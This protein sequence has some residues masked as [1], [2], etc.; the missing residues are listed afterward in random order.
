[1]SFTQSSNVDSKPVGV[2]PF[3]PGMS[4]F[5]AGTKRI[6]RLVRPISH[7]D[8][9]GVPVRWALSD[10]SDL[11]ESQLSHIDTFKPGDRVFTLN[12]QGEATYRILTVRSWLPGEHPCW[13]WGYEG[14]SFGVKEDKL[15]P[16]TALEVADWVSGVDS[17][18]FAFD[19]GVITQRLDDGKFTVIHDG[20]RLTLTAANLR[21]DRRL[22]AAKPAKPNQPSTRVDDYVEIT[23]PTHMGDAKWV[24]RKGQ[25]RNVADDGA[26]RVMG[27][28]AWF[29]ASSVKRLASAPVAVKAQFPELVAKAEG[30]LVASKGT[31]LVG[32]PDDKRVIGVDL[33]KG[34]D[35]TVGVKRA[36]NALETPARESDDRE[37]A[38]GLWTWGDILG[39]CVV[40]CL[41][42]LLAWGLLALGGCAG[43]T[44]TP[45]QVD[46]AREVRTNE[47]GETSRYERVIEINVPETGKGGGK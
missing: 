28:L 3:E 15:H 14:S 30:A 1:M 36:G 16:D 13:R 26:V 40:A 20:G 43:A 29:P 9:R 22:S 46:L 21:L 27:I 39:W 37:W 45:P 2:Y 4:V 6:V 41:L 12:P 34:P 33:A 31:A 24:G 11:L 32:V 35:W 19:G 44:V 25:V 42:A 10:G 38:G 47:G 17:G 5:V 18:G 23:G 8:A 7:T